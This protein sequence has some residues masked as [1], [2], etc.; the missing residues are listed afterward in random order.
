MAARLTHEARRDFFARMERGD[1]LAVG[2]RL[3]L[4]ENGRIGSDLDFVG[5]GH[6]AHEPQPPVSAV[7]PLLVI[8]EH[9]QDLMVRVVG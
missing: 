4:I 7:V 2:I 6:D 9:L 8:G 5:R 3:E 1:E